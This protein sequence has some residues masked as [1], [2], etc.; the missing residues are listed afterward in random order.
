[1]SECFQSVLYKIIVHSLVDEL[2]CCWSSVN[3]IGEITGFVI[4]FRGVHYELG[5]ISC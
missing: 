1:M 3:G 5:D 2:K 4:V